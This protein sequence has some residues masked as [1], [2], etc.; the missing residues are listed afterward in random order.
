MPSPQANH[1]FCCL[2]PGSVKNEVSIIHNFK[3]PSFYPEGK[4]SKKNVSKIFQQVKE[5]KGFLQFKNGPPVMLKC[6]TFGLT[7]Q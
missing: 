3:V 4:S 1:A 7:N 5:E 6:G 2:W